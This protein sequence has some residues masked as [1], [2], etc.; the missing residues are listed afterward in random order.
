MIALWSESD[1]VCLHST[2]ENLAINYFVSSQFGVQREILMVVR[3]SKLRTRLDLDKIVTSMIGVLS[4]FYSD[5]V[6]MVIFLCL[7]F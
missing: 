3:R 1:C 5:L 6:R 4:P 7:A 2:Q